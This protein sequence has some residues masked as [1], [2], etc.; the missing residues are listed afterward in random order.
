MSSSAESTSAA[1]RSI[2]YLGMDVHKES[3]TIAVLPEGAKSPTPL[4]R[5]PND[6]SKL[7]RWLDRAAR[8]VLRFE[9]AC[10]AR[11]D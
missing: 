2:I 10:K 1:A 11:V 7:K 5:I 3:I 4:D 8:A 6:L 9:G